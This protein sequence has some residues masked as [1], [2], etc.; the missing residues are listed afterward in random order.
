MC[1]ATDDDGRAPGEPLRGKTAGKRRCKCRVAGSSMTRVRD[2]ALIIQSGM[3]S[4]T[5]HPW[6]K[7]SRL[8]ELT[9]LQ[10]TVSREVS[11]IS[12]SW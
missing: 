5:A 12:E 7:Q 3:S 1:E 4:T 2:V 10:N 11:G 9:I 8:W 6:Y